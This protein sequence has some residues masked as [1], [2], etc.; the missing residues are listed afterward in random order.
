MAGD[1]REVA[2]VGSSWRVYDRDSFIA[3][4]RYPTGCGGGTYMY[5]FNND[6]QVG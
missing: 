5:H 1:D 4:D 6:V 3:D 2:C